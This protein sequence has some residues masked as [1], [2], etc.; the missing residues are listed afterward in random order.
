M[1]WRARELAGWSV[2]RT[3]GLGVA[4][5]CLVCLICL[6]CLGRGSE[7]VGLR[8]AVQWDAD[9]GCGA[10]VGACAVLCCAGISLPEPG[11]GGSVDDVNGGPST[12]SL[13][14]S[15][16]PT[17]RPAHEGRHPLGRLLPTPRP[18]AIKRAAGRGRTESRRGSVG[19]ALQDSTRADM[20]TRLCQGPR[21][22][23]ASCSWVG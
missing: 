11:K 7:A 17:A 12:L 16:R 6:I 22:R 9:V 20:S 10:D 5:V 15:A 8:G 23:C 14:L 1:G 21:G 3:V 19:F 18:C 4:L 13:S 2:G